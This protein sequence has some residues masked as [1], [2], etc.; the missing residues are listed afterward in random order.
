MI[1][2][3]DSYIPTEI[4]DTTDKAIINCVGPNA[5]DVT[6]NNIQVAILS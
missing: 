4:A 2:E 6:L 1:T 5:I 3:I